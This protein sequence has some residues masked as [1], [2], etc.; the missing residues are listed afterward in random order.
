MQSFVHSQ[1]EI[2]SSPAVLQTKK[3]TFVRY[4]SDFFTWK[5]LMKVHS[6]VRIPSPLLSSLTSRIT[7]NRRKKVMEMRALSS[8]F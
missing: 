2:V 5:D 6:K 1:R 7:L 4:I 3:K 8:V